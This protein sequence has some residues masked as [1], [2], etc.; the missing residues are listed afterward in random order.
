[1]KHLSNTLQIL[2]HVFFSSDFV[3]PK[4]QYTRYCVVYQTNDIEIPVYSNDF[5]T[6]YPT[7]QTTSI[8]HCFW[9]QLFCP[10]IPFCVLFCHTGKQPIRNIYLV[11]ARSTP[12]S[13]ITTMIKYGYHDFLCLLV[14]TSQYLVI[15]PLKS[16]F[17]LGLTSRNLLPPHFWRFFPRFFLYHC[18]SSGLDMAAGNEPLLLLRCWCSVECPT[19]F[20]CGRSGWAATVPWWFSDLPCRKRLHNYGKSPLW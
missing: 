2:Q 12:F 11:K 19:L 15:F 17:L 18:Y 8:P 4:N 1:M 7:Y 10:P 13:P 3:Y 16:L 6:F 5:D 9:C 20:H 14:L